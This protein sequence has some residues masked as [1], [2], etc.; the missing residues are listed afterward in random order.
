[1]VKNFKWGTE[2]KCGVIGCDKQVDW[3]EF[4]SYLACE[5]HRN[6]KWGLCEACQT[7]KTTHTVFY[8]IYHDN[9]REEEDLKGTKEKISFQ[10]EIIE[11][12]LGFYIS[13]ELRE[14]LNAAYQKAQEA[15]KIVSELERL[16]QEY[17]EKKLNCASN[18]IQEKGGKQ[19]NVYE[20]NLCDGCGDE[21][22]NRQQKLKNDYQLNVLNKLIVFSPETIAQI[23]KE[24]G[25]DEAKEIVYDCGLHNDKIKGE[26]LRIR[27]HFTGKLPFFKG[28][29][30][31]ELKKKKKANFQKLKQFFQD[32]QIMQIVDKGTFGCI[33]WYANGTIEEKWGPSLAEWDK[34]NSYRFWNSAKALSLYEINKVLENLDREPNPSEKEEE[35]LLDRNNEK[36]EDTSSLSDLELELIKTYFRKNKIKK[37]TLKNG[38]LII[39]HNNN[40]NEV[41]TDDI[42]VNN[43]EQQLIRDSL[44]RAN[45]N[46][47]TSQELGLNLENV[48][49][50]TDNSPSGNKYFWMVGGIVVGV[51][52][53]G[54]LVFSWRR[55][56]PKNN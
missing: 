43:A 7:E 17:W 51:L 23:K 29:K 24:I 36:K 2:N 14:K 37:I 4:T 21:L 12:F 3:G 19:T 22:N 50:N 15:E 52:V 25:K 10:K 53:T 45:K 31:A 11:R 40:N 44:K 38:E 6:R 27:Y 35:K 46:E 55:K 42:L 20:S 48:S 56:K 33:I 18:F 34:I 8:D 49:T 54:I 41:I 39:T 28:E 32:H 30:S 9:Y 5:N 16:T 47:L 26:Q 1:M 13:R